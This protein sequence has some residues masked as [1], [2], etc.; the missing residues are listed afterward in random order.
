M[1]VTPRNPLVLTLTL[2]KSTQNFLTTLRSKYFPSHRNFLQAHVTLFHAIP[3]QRF[4]E[5]DEELARLC[6][7]TN[8]WEVFVNDPRKMGNRG[9]MVSVR[10][11]RQSI[12]WIHRRILNFLKD[13]VKEPKDELTEQDKRHWGKTAHV[14]ILNKAEKEEEVQLCLDEVT[15][16]FEGMKG[17]D[18]KFGQKVGSAIGL[19]M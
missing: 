12:E 14:T 11:R 3:P 5:V 8:P 2:D 1:A 17:P 4:P 10:D 19:Q 7:S 6:A 18:D 9:V 16:L 13:G 15:E